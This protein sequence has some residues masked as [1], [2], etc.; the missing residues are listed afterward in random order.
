[1]ALHSA[2]YTIALVFPG[3]ARPSWTSRTSAHGCTPP[4][5][6]CVLSPRLPPLPL[7]KSG[8]TSLPRPYKSDTHLSPSPRVPHRVLLL[9]DRPPRPERP[10][11]RRARGRAAAV[12]KGF[13]DPGRCRNPPPPPSRTNWTRLLHPSVLIGHVSSTY[14]FVSSTTLPRLVREGA[15][16]AGREQGGR[17]GLRARPRGA[18]SRCSRKR[19]VPAPPPSY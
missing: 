1:M 18:P 12:Y 6:R 10:R 16:F 8:R 14:P 11:A 13:V 15:R 17:R 4:S 3:R 5:T 2:L 9:S 19:G 7:H